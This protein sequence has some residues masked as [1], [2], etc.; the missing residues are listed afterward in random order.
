MS[1]GAKVIS[2]LLVVIVLL[3]GSMVT[4]AGGPKHFVYQA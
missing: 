1:R 4:S 3:L 2:A